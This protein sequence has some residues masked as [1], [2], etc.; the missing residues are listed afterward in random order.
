MKTIIRYAGGKSR[1][2]KYIKNYISP[3]TN[4]LISPF[5]GGG[6]IECQLAS[7][8]I[9]VY[10]FDI[11]DV[12]VNFWQVILQNPN[13]VADILDTLEPT[14]ECY[15]NI[16]EKLM[17]WDITQKMFQGYK[18][19][20]YKRK[21]IKL[22]NITACAYY[23]YNHNLSYGPMYLGW[24]SSIYTPKKYKAIIQRVRN[25]YIPNLS[26]KQSHFDKTIIDFPND[27]MYLDPPYYLKKE[28]DN[29]MFKGIYPNPNF[30]FHHT[31]FDHKK[32]RDLLYNHKGKFILSYNNCSTIRKWYKDYD[33]YYPVWKYSYGSGETRIGKNKI[34]NTPKQSHE[35]LI[36][37]R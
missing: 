31:G 27:L 18:T 13:E 3:T 10:G 6:S 5:I 34:D 15:N 21:P 16:K 28:N 32:L 23:F 30:D 37:K 20:Y 8:G 14:K 26:V 7:M 29:K 2:F 19:N 1:A 12:L 9:E 22:D 11:F 24:L 33:L 35:I 36:I 17:C 25:F 4:K